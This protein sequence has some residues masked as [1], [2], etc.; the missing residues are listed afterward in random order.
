MNPIIRTVA[1]LAIAL[2][3]CLTAVPAA[4]AHE[5]DQMTP[6]P[7]QLADLGPYIN[8]LY[9]SRI[10]RAVEK[11]NEDIRRAESGRGTVRRASRPSNRGRARVNESMSPAEL[12]ERAQSPDGVA[13]QVW[14]SFGSA[15]NLIERLESE[16]K[17]DEL[18]SKYP[19]DKLVGYN[20]AD[21]GESI[22]TGLYFPLD[23]RTAFRLWHAATMNLYGHNVGTDKIGHFTDMGYH[24]FREYREKLRKGANSADAML[25]A[26]RLGTDGAFSE[27]AALGYTTA[28]AYSNADL[29]ANYVGCLFYRNLTEPVEL[30][31]KTY[32]PMLERDGSYWKVA[33]FVKQDP[34]FVARFISHHYDEALN[35]SHFEKIIQKTLRKKVEERV[36]RL[37]AYYKPLYGTQAPRPW[38]EKTAKELS[39]YYGAEYGHSGKWDEL[40]GLWNTPKDSLVSKSK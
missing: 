29:V 38:F 37:M 35:P 22:Y 3:V 10:E 36:P 14:L 26:K 18:Q 34:Q 24:Y 21:R 30:K 31:G 20:A 4:S 11:L 28:G 27:K 2:S 17:S 33:A 23:P 8:E 16:L 12:L 40:I 7:K 5:T 9:V 6:P 19:E 15:V 39:T 1:P 13:N 32:P 25:A